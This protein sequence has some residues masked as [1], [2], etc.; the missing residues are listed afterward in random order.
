MVPNLRCMRVHASSFVRSELAVGV[1]DV[2]AAIIS[3][4][5][6]RI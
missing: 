4:L 3:I 6:E 2:F 1:L 5:S